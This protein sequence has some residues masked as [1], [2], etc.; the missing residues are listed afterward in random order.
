MTHILPI[1]PLVVVS[2]HDADTL[3]FEIPIYTES[4]VDAGDLAEHIR[5]NFAPLAPHQ[6][7]ITV[8]VAARIHPS[9]RFPD[10][11]RATYQLTLSGLGR[12]DLKPETFRAKIDQMVAEYTPPRGVSSDHAKSFE[13]TL[14]ESATDAANEFGRPF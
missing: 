10:E 9:V 3:R 8:E 11:P 12:S 7:A 4:D 2:D 6:R 13:A 14:R 1:W 5:V